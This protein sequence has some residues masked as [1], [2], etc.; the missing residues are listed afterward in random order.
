MKFDTVT[1]LH[2]T[3]A[4]KVKDKHLIFPPGL[5]AGAAGAGNPVGPIKWRPL[6][7]AHWNGARSIAPHGLWAF[8]AGQSSALRRLAGFAE[9][10]NGE[11]Q[12][13]L[14][15]SVCVWCSLYR[16]VCR[17]QLRHS[18]GSCPPNRGTAS[19]LNNTKVCRPTADASHRCAGS[20]SS[21]VSFVLEPKAFLGATK[22]I[23]QWWSCDKKCTPFL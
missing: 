9:V 5:T 19:R 10:S 20:F 2:R 14:G 22:K 7:N 3:F 17:L 12:S 16:S 6:Q 15:R 18:Y 1:T 4:A 8:R 21:L 11:S 23:Y 13:R